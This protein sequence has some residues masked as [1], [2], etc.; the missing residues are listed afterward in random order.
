M[1]SIIIICCGLAIASVWTAD[2]I[3]GK[4]FDKKHGLLKARDPESGSLLLPHWIA[5]YLTAISLIAAGIGMLTSQ[6][7]ASPLSFLALG[8]LAYTSINSL[9]W[10]LA[11][12]E[13]RTYAIPMLICLAGVVVSL[14]MLV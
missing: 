14:V 13:R 9:S 11:E 2:I 5:E 3:S 7:W 1:P 10:A 8:A 4:K 6:P 12:K